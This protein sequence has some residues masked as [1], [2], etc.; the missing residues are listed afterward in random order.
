MNPVGNRAEV[1]KILYLS[2]K[3]TFGTYNYVARG[4]TSA[5]GRKITCI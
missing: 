3:K 2:V 5:P 4:Q 1:V